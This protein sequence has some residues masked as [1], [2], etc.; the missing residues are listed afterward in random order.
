MKGNIA[1]VE[2]GWIDASIVA[3]DSLSCFLMKKEA[4]K[5]APNWCEFFW[6]CWGVI[7]VSSHLKKTKHIRLLQLSVFSQPSAGWPSGQG[8]RSSIQLLCRVLLLSGSSKRSVKRTH[9]P[10]FSLDNLGKAKDLSRALTASLKRSDRN[11]NCLR[12]STNT[13]KVRLVRPPRLERVESEDGDPKS[14]SLVQQQRPAIDFATVWPNLM[15]F[16]ALFDH[17]AR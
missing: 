17:G 1:A 14:H 15:C 4:S 2:Y 6:F 12:R 3:V 7:D 5:G 8:C 10:F 13:Q 16:E 9:L 11:L